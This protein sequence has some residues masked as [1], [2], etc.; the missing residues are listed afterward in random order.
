LWWAARGDWD[1]AHACAQEDEG[2]P[3]D[4]VHAYL[5]RVEGD[6]G[7]ARYWYAQAGKPEATGPLDAEWT[8]IAGALLA[9]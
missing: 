5:H 7:N 9:R 6:L 8:A 1:R 4:W 2:G 3:A